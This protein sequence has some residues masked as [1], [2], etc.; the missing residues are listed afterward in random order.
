[1]EWGSAPAG[2]TRAGPSVHW[3]KSESEPRQAQL[4]PSRGH[5]SC[6]DVLQHAAQGGGDFLVQRQTEAINDRTWIMFSVAAE[7][8][9]QQE[10]L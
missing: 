4:V 2:P 1:M 3:Q 6:E 9:W 7:R 5:E 8:G 10:N